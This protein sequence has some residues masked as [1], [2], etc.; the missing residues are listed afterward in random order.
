MVHRGGGKA[1]SERKAGV[2]DLSARTRTE[3]VVSESVV[4]FGVGCEAS[5]K[6]TFKQ[7]GKGASQVNATKGCRTGSIL[8]AAFKD[9]LNQALL[10]V[11]GLTVELPDHSV[12]RQQEALVQERAARL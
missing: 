11:H 12:G 9:G 6:E 8:L 2:M 1:D 4:S 7:F 5:H 3:F 10:P